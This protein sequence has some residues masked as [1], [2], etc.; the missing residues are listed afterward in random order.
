MVGH[1][2]VVDVESKAFGIRGKAQRCS[3]NH[4][5]ISELGSTRLASGEEGVI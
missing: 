3:C 5:G 2:L 4:R 1:L